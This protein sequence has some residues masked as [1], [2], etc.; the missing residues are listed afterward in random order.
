MSMHK[1]NIIDND[2]G[3]RTDSYAGRKELFDI[4][5]MVSAH[6]INNIKTFKKPFKEFRY[7]AVF[8]FR[9]SRDR[10]FHITKYDKSGNVIDSD[11]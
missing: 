1:T 5:I 8:L 10:I 9:R 2:P 6:D 7:L 11:N 4:G 3:S